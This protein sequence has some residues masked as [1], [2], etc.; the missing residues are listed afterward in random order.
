[1][2]ESC[3]GVEATHTRFI[4]I[5]HIRS[6]Q[7]ATVHLQK[8]EEAA[9][10]RQHYEDLKKYVKSLSKAEL[11]ERLLKAMVQL[12]EQRRYYW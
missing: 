12:E 11:Q 5:R 3:P 2:T 10:E 7:L 9:E 6:A 4:L 1:M 8:A